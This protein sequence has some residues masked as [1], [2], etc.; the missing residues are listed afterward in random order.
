MFNETEELWC[1]K[2]IFL[3]I[4]LFTQRNEHYGLQNHLKLTTPLHVEK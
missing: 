3:Y 1:M 2:V 4:M